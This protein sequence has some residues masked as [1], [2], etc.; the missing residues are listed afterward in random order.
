MEEKIGPDTY[1]NEDCK[2]FDQQLAKLDMKKVYEAM[3]NEM[4]KTGEKRFV[5]DPKT[6]NM[7]GEKFG[8]VILERVYE[9]GT[10]IPEKTVLK[11]YNDF[12][13]GIL[14][15]HG[16][17]HGYDTFDGLYLGHRI[18]KK[19]SMKKNP[20]FSLRRI[21]GENFVVDTVAKFDEEPWVN[22]TAGRTSEKVAR[23]KTINPQYAGQLEQII[24]GINEYSKQREDNINIVLDEEKDPIILSYGPF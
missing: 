7:L 1:V 14:S 8:N 17:E 13:S 10:A 22:I 18:F 23:I 24:T 19:D 4:S 21:L 20:F 16:L 15:E 3:C 6:G 12:L 9:E 2:K 11:N 5:V